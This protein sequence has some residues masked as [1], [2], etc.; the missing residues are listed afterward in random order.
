MAITISREQHRQYENSMR[1]RTRSSSSLVGE[2]EDIA[3]QA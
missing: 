1:V 3:G 2:L